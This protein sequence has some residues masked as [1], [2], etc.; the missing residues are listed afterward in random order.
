ME[1]IGIVIP[2]YNMWKEMTLPCLKSIYEHTVLPYIY[3][4][5]R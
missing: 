4:Y 5:G 3:I 2:V 1:K